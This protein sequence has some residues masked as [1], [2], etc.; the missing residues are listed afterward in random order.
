MA[1]S[2]KAYVRKWHSPRHLVWLNLVIPVGY[3][4]RIPEWI[5]TPNRQRSF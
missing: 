1:K 5:F 4:L 2:L 3:L